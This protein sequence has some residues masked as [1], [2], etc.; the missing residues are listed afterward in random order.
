GARGRELPPLVGA[1]GAGGREGGPPRA[2]DA[3][4]RGGAPGAEGEAA[5]A[6]GPVRARLTPEPVPCP[7]QRIAHRAPRRRCNRAAASRSQDAERR[8][9]RAMTTRWISLVPS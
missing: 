3:G 8:R 4:V 9:S 1:D 2:A 7:K 5:R 6:A